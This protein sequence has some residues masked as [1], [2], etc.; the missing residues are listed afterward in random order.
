MFL[1]LS[2]S[3]GDSD[4]GDD[5]CDGNDVGDPARLS[6]Q[7][8]LMP[9][10]QM[11]STRQR[12]MQVQTTNSSKP[13]CTA[14]VNCLNK[15]DAGLSCAVVL[16]QEIVCL[17]RLYVRRFYLPKRRGVVSRFAIRGA[18]LLLMEHASQSSSLKRVEASSPPLRNETAISH[19]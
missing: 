14:S 2:G 4:D 19:K 15:V 5:I 11:H 17:Q 18:M 16:R 8:A 9:G 10:M 7:P 1:G 12:P 13:S 6:Q 3:R